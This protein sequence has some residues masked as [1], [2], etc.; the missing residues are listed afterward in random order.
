MSLMLQVTTDHDLA[1]KRSAEATENRELTRLKA[2]SFAHLPAQW[3]G[4]RYK[5]TEL[6]DTAKEREEAE[7]KARLRLATTNVKI[8]C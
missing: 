2:Y 3:K 8:G 5:R 6:A 4:K 7:E 1:R